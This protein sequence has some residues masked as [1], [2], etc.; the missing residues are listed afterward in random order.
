MPS[1]KRHY[2]VTLADALLAHDAA[3]QHGGLSGILNRGLIESAISRPYSG[4]YRSMD[5]K[6]AALLHSLARNHGFADGNKRT[7]LLLV[8]LLI[9]RSG[10]TLHDRD[11]ARL[12]T[13]LENLI[14][15][16]AE[17]LLSVAQLREWMRQRLRKRR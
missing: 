9:D 1:G 15:D 6:A 13:D 17:G 8:H 7:C 14:V 11:L 12:N 16:T 10:Y 4:Y 3:L 5:A 2:R